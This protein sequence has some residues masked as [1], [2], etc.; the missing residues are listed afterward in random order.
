MRCLVTLF[1]PRYGASGSQAEGRADG[2]SL[3]GQT[4]RRGPQPLPCPLWPFAST[5]AALQAPR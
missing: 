3:V 5:V 1:Q 2:H 4:T